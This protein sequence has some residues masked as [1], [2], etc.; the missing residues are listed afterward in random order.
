MNLHDEAYFYLYNDVA[1]NAVWKSSDT[2]VFSV[3][4]VDVING[5]I[6]INSHYAG[7]A[8]LYTDIK[9][10]RTKVYIKVY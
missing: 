1:R 4:P 6:K 7:T 8:Y 10:L 2:N 9:G 3:G 5:Y